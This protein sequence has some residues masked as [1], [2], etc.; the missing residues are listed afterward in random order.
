[1]VGR[2]TGLAPRV[3]GRSEG[4]EWLS[5]GRQ[6]S[7]GRDQTSRVEPNELA[8]D[9]ASP[10]RRKPTEWEREGISTTGL[11]VCAEGRGESTTQATVSGKLGRAGVVVWQVQ[12]LGGPGSLSG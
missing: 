7:R 2:G 5:T 6:G 12:R 9:P 11:G 8:E 4:L 1:M 3:C 10:H